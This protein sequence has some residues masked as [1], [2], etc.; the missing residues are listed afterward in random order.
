MGRLFVRGPVVTGRYVG[1]Q[2]ESVVDWLDTGDIARIYADGTIEIVDRAKDVIKSGG[3]WISAV[4][5]EMAAMSH[6]AIRQAAAIGVHHPR[7]EERPLLICSLAVGA[8]VTAA[9][10]SAHMAQS[11]AKW[12][13][14]DQILFVDELPLTATGKL[15]KL[16]LRR[17]HNPP[18]AA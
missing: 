18:A 12:W 17:T 6:P 14:P 15:N 11:M 3:E 8:T 16:E 13:L 4:Q 5:L 1:D 7:W 2:E 10:L 9:E